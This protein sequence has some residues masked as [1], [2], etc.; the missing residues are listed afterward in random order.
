MPAP[1]LDIHILAIVQVIIHGIRIKMEH[2]NKR[3]LRV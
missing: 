1:W 3:N 2:E